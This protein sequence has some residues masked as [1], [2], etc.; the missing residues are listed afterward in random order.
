MVPQ[1]GEPSLWPWPGQV[2]ELRLFHSK[3]YIDAPHAC[4]QMPEEGNRSPGTRVICSF[5]PLYRS[6]H[7]ILEE[8][9]GLLT[10]GLLF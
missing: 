9:P 3:N 4:P 1:A 7:Q 10:T 6:G 5:E 8:Q 2:G